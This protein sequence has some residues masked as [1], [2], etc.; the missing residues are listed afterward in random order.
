MP[1]AGPLHPTEGVR[2]LLTLEESDGEQ[3]IYAAAIYT[4]DTRFDYRA[5]LDPTG[6]ASLESLGDPAP[7]AHLTKLENLCKSTARAAS[8][9]AASGLAPWP[10]RILRWRL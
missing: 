8:R 4:P 2:L 3:A 1:T 5:T 9:K 7:A 6:A 10:P